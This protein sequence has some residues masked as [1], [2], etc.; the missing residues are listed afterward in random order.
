MKK[1]LSLFLLLVTLSHAQEYVNISVNTIC[2]DS[3]NEVSK[4]RITIKSNKLDLTEDAIQDN[5]GG[6]V[7]IPEERHY[8]KTESKVYRLNGVVEH[9]Y[10]RKINQFTSVITTEEF[11][12]LKSSKHLKFIQKITLEK[13]K[14]MTTNTLNLSFNKKLFSKECQ[15]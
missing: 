4:F 10:K 2:A 5:L 1:Y 9:N 6:Y 13:S 15:K 8:L 3:K 7:D 14:R 12:A 11:T